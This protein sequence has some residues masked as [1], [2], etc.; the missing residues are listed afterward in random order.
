MA[1]KKDKEMKEI[2][3]VLGKAG[4]KSGSVLRV[5]VIK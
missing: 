5:K 4:K 2:L 3:K 1:S